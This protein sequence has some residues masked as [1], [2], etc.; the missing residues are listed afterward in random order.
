[1][2]FADVNPITRMEDPFLLFSGLGC[3]ALC[4]SAEDWNCSKLLTNSERVADP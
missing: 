2:P 1:M 3:R 4:R